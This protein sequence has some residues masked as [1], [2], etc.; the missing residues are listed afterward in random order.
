MDGTLYETRKH[1]VSL[2]T[3]YAL[4]QLKEK[5]YRVSVISS[6]SIHELA[7]LQKNVKNFPFDAWIL[8]GGALILDREDGT[9][10]QYSMDPELVSAFAD[11]ALQKGL[12]WR[13]TTLDGNWFGTR[14]TPKER[15]HMNR[16]YLNA[17]VYKPF[18][19]KTDKAMN[20]VVWTTEDDE[21]QDI[22]AQFPDHSCVVYSSCVEVRAPGVSKEDAL[23]EMKQKHR[24]AEVICFGDGANDAAMLKAADTGVAMGNGC[25]AV[26]E[27]ADYVIGPIQEDG[28]YHFLEEHGVID[29]APRQ[30][31][32]D[33]DL[34]WDQRILPDED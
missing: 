22:L 15:Y 21:K 4:E 9:R 24:Y 34:L 17:P 29:Q 5:G 32:G 10:T 30:L 20:I 1:A 7:N 25:S 27:A 33:D 2:L 28:V 31:L 12:I 16:L 18:D 26:K 11:Y 14:P 13:Y 8:E 23:M 3:Q 6:R 19:P